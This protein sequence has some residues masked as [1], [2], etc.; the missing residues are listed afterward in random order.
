MAE[1]LPRLLEG[2][3][4][5]L[6]ARLLLWGVGQAA[7][8]VATAVLVELAFQSLGAGAMPGAG[9]LAGLTGAAATLAYLRYR[10][11]LDAERL[12][13]DYVVDL[14]GR[15]YRKVL[16][17]DTRTLQRRSKGGM[18]LRLLGDLTAIRQWISL[19]VARLLVG[20]TMAVG[21]LAGL[22]WMN[23]TLAASLAALLA[24]SAVVSV[25]LGGRL[26]ESTADLRQRRA[27]LGTEVTE[28]LNAVGVVQAFGQWRREERRMNTRSRDVAAASVRRARWIG[29]LRAAA[30]AGGALAIVLVLAVGGLEVARG[31]AD[32]ATVASLMA[33][34]GMLGGR[35]RELGRVYEYR[36]GAR[37]AGERLDELLAIPSRNPKHGKALPEGPGHLRLAGVQLPGTDG[38]INAEVAPGSVVAIVGSNGAGKSTLLQAIAGLAPLSRGRLALDGADLS[39]CRPVDRSRAIGILGPDLTLL[40]G[41][42]ARN[43]CYRAPRVPERQ[44]WR[45]RQLTGLDELIERLPEKT[46]TRIRERG[47]NL[48]PGERQRLALARALLGGPRLLLL[49]EPEANLDGEAAGVVARVLEARLA[50]T[51]FVTHR[52]DHLHLAD[53][54]WYLED[55]RIAER[56][57]PADLLRRGGPTARLFGTDTRQIVP[58][59][60]GDS[61]R[62]RADAAESRHN[63]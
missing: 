2:R 29:A 8:A 33:V 51:L 31:A 48:S 41:T 6:L 61:A 62:A 47:A 54:V 13:Q 7:A 43:L 28:K 38:R 37:V 23:F 14:R 25:R 18:T 39:R 16:R 1:R 10:E 12:G 15:L 27:R 3:R 58:F 19:G 17:L 40:R 44:R 22:A 50:T 20:G 34:A 55:G 4:R 21:A 56:G 9:L 11:Q 35:I 52:P 36:Q 49:D 30:E 63:S 46:R 45:I 24:L 26:R 5:G 32:A 60:G 42:V 53:E 57:R 59:P